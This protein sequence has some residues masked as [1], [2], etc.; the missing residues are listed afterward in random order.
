MTIIVTR[1]FW[2]VLKMLGH[3]GPFLVIDYI[4]APKILGYQ[5]GNLIFGTNLI[6]FFHLR[7]SGLPKSL[8]LE[9]RG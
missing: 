7:N 9:C 2:V 5:S 3:V 4:V 1:I 6:G 8:H